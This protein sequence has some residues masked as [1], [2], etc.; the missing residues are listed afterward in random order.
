MAIFDSK[1]NGSAEDFFFC[2][3]CRK[4]R[5][6]W[7]K[8]SR[9]KSLMNSLRIWRE[10]KALLNE[11][12]QHFY[13]I[14][15]LMT[16]QLFGFF[17]WDGATSR[18]L[19]MPRNFLRNSGSALFSTLQDRMDEVLDELDTRRSIYCL[20]LSRLRFLCCIDTAA[21][22]GRAFLLDRTELSSPWKTE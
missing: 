7:D 13:S 2:V 6:C 16:R 4:N 19:V 11:I 20:L 22:L 10:Q 3:K 8:I 17:L 9:G 5:F 21:C 12:A 14:D 18:W 15:F 1:L